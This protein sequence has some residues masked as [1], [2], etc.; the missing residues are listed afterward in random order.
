MQAQATQR[1]PTANCI[2]RMQMSLDLS[3]LDGLNGTLLTISVP[4]DH[5]GYVVCQRPSSYVLDGLGV[6]VGGM[7]VSIALVRVSNVVVD[8]DVFKSE[9]E[10]D[11][12]TVLA[13]L[14]LL[15]VVV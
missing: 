2:Q 8:N 9:P 10:L 4:L 14:M 15:L 11:R 3:Q 7:D 1:T 12:K 6:G 13:E 5:G